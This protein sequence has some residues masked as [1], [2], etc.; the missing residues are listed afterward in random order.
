MRFKKAQC[1]CNDSPIFRGIVILAET[2]TSAHDQV[3]ACIFWWD[4]A[5]NNSIV[6]GPNALNAFAKA[7]LPRVPLH[8]CVDGWWQL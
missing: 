1:I 3:G 4:V 8:I 6:L 2:Y 7:P 5:I